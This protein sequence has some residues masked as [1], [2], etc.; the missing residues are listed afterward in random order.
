MN[1]QYKQERSW[2]TR[3]WTLMILLLLSG[4]FGKMQASSDFATSDVNRIIHQP[5][6]TEPYIAIR[7]LI[8]DAS[9]SE[10][11]FFVH[12][13]VDNITKGPL[14]YFDD[15]YLFSLNEEMAWPGGGSGSY[16][17]LAD[18]CYDYDEWWSNTYR[19]TVDGVTYTLKF[20]N[21]VNPSSKKCY[22]D[23]YIFLDKFFT[24]TNHTLKIK[25]IW[26]KDKK[27]VSGV[28][29]QYQINSPSL[30]VGEPTSA[31]MTGDGK[32]KISGNLS[33]TLPGTFQIG[34]VETVDKTKFTDDLKSSF[35]T[36]AK[37][38][39]YSDQT[40]NCYRTNYYDIYKT[41]LE[42]IY[43][44]KASVTKYEHNVSLYQWYDISV[45]GYAR[46]KDFSCSEGQMWD[47][48]VIP[49]WNVDGQG[50]N[51]DGTWSIYRYPEGKANERVLLKSGI[52]DLTGQNVVEIPDWDKSFTYEVSF[53]PTGGSRHEEL[54][55]KCNFTLKRKWNF[56]KF[57][58]Q[59][60]SDASS[61][62]KL[63]WV[64]E[65]LMNA[66]GSNSYVLKIQRSTDYDS[67]KPN[68]ATW[69]DLDQITI[70]SKE[71]S[72]GTYVDKSNKSNKI[73]YYYRLVVNVM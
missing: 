43:H 68:S 62:I 38:A 65:K 2:F 54:T 19:A 49:T 24:G 26:R 48:T 67:K 1:F 71:T 73:T 13:K 46:A 4:G 53:I 45:P 25:G 35:S 11:S 61:N 66:S 8:Y 7:L 52:K 20:W 17:Y 22:V 39:S 60:E 56:Q 31:V 40:L 59:A 16:S 37:Q 57:S 51:Q 50:K 5:T 32:M 72:K 70:T 69:E 6:V 18:A 10:H 58:A 36:S 12:D 15:K 47:K 30:G 29:I 63:E 28:E 21:P 27:T 9:S 42:F 41:S 44:T 34:S 14:I 33:A 3:M 55:Q 64:H 23:A